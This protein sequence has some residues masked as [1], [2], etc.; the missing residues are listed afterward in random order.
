MV[1]ILNSAPSGDPL[2]SR[3][4]SHTKRVCIWK[5]VDNPVLD[6]LWSLPSAALTPFSAHQPVRAQGSAST[7]FLLS[8]AAGSLAFRATASRRT[9]S[10]DYQTATRRN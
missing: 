8:R 3:S 9:A 6:P 1:P 7:T 4:I 2:P 5:G 10:D